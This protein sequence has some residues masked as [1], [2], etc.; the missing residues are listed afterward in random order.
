[1]ARNIGMWKFKNMEMG[2]FFLFFSDIWVS[3]AKMLELCAMVQTK[4]LEPVLIVV[5]ETLEIRVLM[6]TRHLFEFRL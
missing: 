2:K 4:T 1:M 5:H 6:E 3:L